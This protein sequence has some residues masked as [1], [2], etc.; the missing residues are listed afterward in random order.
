[1]SLNWRINEIED[2]E[3]LWEKMP[4]DYEPSFMDSCRTDNGVVYRL[5]T[6]TSALIW[7]CM[8]IGIGQINKKT[9]KEFCLRLEMWQDATGPLLSNGKKDV[10]ITSKDVR[11][12]MGLWTNV[13]FKVEA[14]STFT[15]KLRRI[16]ED[17]PK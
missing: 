11:R 9:Y 13:T 6:I 14:W 8:G 4:E 12:R 7:A 5:D 1:M 2:S 3:K 17:R 15:K 16:V 10:R